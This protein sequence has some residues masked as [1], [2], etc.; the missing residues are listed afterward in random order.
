MPCHIKQKN[1]NNKPITN[2]LTSTCT[3]AHIVPLFV[4]LRLCHDLRGDP[5][6]I[7]G[8]V[9]VQGPN[10]DLQLGLHRLHLL[11]SATDKSQSTYT[12][13]L[14]SKGRGRE[15]GRERRSCLQL[16]YTSAVCVLPPAHHRVPCSWRRTGKGPPYG[17]P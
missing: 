7:D 12:L 3:H 5:G 14:G 4:D 15:R 13:T 6:P 16:R 1:E 8:W 2:C 10:E 9:G 17:P 11:L